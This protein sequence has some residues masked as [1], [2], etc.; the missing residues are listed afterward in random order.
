MK[1]VLSLF[2][3][4]FLSIIFFG[5]ARPVAAV[6]ASESTQIDPGD[7]SLVQFEAVTE[8]E[9]VWTHW[10]AGQYALAD[11]GE[12]VWAGTAMGLLRW[13]KAAGTYERITEFEGFPQASVYAV[14]TDSAGNR[15]F[16]GDHGLSRLDSQNR[17][18]HFTTANSGLF[19]DFVDGI[20]VA[21]DGTV[22]TSHG[23]PSN[24]VS[25]LTPDGTWQPF[26]N[27]SVAISTDYVDILST[28]NL[29]PL[30]LVSGD[31]IWMGYWVYD[32]HNWTDRLPSVDHARPR[33]AAGTP[34]LWSPE[35]MA[36]GGDSAGQIWALINKVVA[37]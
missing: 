28:R 1:V 31:E 32:G 27:R 8:D 14:A 23:L 17:W 3:M 4:G 25:R 13:D 22:W 19:S 24:P 21:A 12:S 33:S 2:A 26:P 29:N 5:L 30:W 7:S 6:A 16:G 10:L 15:W 35:P 11:D 34:Q 20:A 37:D 36:L 9:P 18:T